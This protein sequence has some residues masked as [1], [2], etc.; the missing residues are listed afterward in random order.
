MRSGDRSGGAATAK[1][2]VVVKRSDITAVL[3]LCAVVAAVQLARVLVPESSVWSGLSGPQAAAFPV[4]FFGLWRLAI[5]GM[6]VPRAVLV[7]S[8]VCALGA[9]GFSSSTS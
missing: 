6:R 9:M 1:R 5:D 4:F 8:A 2:V 7:L 3:L